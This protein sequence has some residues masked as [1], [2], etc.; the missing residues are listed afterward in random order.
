MINGGFLFCHR[1]AVDRLSMYFWI[2]TLLLVIKNTVK[3]KK[4][5]QI[6]LSLIMSREITYRKSCRLFSMKNSFFNSIQ[7]AFL[8][9]SVVSS[10][11]AAEQNIPEPWT[12][13]RIQ[14][15]LDNAPCRQEEI[16]ELYNSLAIPPLL[17]EGE[18]SNERWSAQKI[19]SLM[20]RLRQPQD[21]TAFYEFASLYQ[22]FFFLHQQFYPSP[23][24]LKDLDIQALP[25][26]IH[27]GRDDVTAT[28]LFIMMQKGYRSYRTK[29]SPLCKFNPAAQYYL[30]VCYL[31]GIAVEKSEM[32]AIA[33]LTQSAKQGYSPG[34]NYLGMCYEYGYGVKMDPYQAYRWYWQAATQGYAPGQTMLASC[35]YFSKGIERDIPRAIQWYRQAAIQGYA[36]AQYYLGFLHVYDRS[37][38]NLHKAIP[39]LI[40]NA[41]QGGKESLEILNH[42]MDELS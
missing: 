11:Y 12:E 24:H 33:L 7:R 22:Q 28:W 1:E 21:I 4:R 32:S 35:Y 31:K 30:G 10:V 16:T 41:E 42:L 9:I 19:N 14:K 8:F 17:K 26:E 18:D 29:L 23:Y 2:S 5:L 27:N 25:P 36:P 37:Q 13:G 6:I 34:Q 40:L 3:N 38:R 39:W 15:Y 20:E